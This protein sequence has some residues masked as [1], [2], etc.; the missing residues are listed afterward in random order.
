MASPLVALYHAQESAEFMLI[1]SNTRRLLF[2]SAMI[3][4][5]ATR[6]SQGVAVMTQKKNCRLEKVALYTEGDLANPHRY[7]T[8]TLPAAGALPREEDFGEQ[9]SLV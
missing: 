7:R 1:S 2:N 3:A 6:D 5:K 4:P 8:K 9:M